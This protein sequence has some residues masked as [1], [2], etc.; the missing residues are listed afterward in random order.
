[1]VTFSWFLSY[2]VMQRISGDV[3]S[4]YFSNHYDRWA[5]LFDQVFSD[6]WVCML[7]HGILPDTLELSYKLKNL[8]V[9]F[10][11]DGESE[12]KFS[13]L[14]DLSQ[15]VEFRRRSLHISL[16]GLDHCTKSVLIIGQPHSVKRELALIDLIGAELPQVSLF[17]KP[18]PLYGKKQYEAS[19]YGEIISENDYYPKV[20][21]AICL[22][23]TLGVE[24]E[25]AG[26][27]VLWWH[28]ASPEKMVIELK[29]R[30]DK[31][32]EQV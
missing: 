30:F 3:K 15:T 9:I 14:F 20:D 17:I 5:V 23:S 4:V 7:Q 24:Y 31:L 16:A 28:D 21:V 8:N 29:K 11:I 1:Y 19:R 2:H 13:K 25:R 27:E 26:V 12:L 22:E 32:Q 6:K 18:H 10:A